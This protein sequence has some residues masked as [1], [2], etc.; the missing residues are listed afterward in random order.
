MSLT[1]DSISYLVITTSVYFDFHLSNLGIIFFGK[2][3]ISLKIGNCKNSKEIYRN[4]EKFVLV[5]VRSTHPFKTFSFACKILN[6]Y[7]ILAFK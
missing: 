3:F 6:Q 4:S 7:T 5:S 2:I 1:S